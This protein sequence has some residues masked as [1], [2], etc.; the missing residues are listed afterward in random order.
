MVRDDPIPPSGW[1]LWLAFALPMALGLALR[2]AAAQGDYW[3]DEA[4]SALFARDAPTP[5]DLLFASGPG[6]GH[7]LNGLWLR[8]VGWGGPPLLGRALSIACGTAAIGVA[9]LIGLRRGL[10]TT[11]LTATMFAVSPILLTY[12]SEARGDAPMLLAL[13]VSIWIVDREL[14]GR[15]PRRAGPWLGLAALLG[16]FADMSMLFGIAAL[17]GWVLIEYGRRMPARRA[18]AAT[19]RLMGRPIGAVVAV[20]LLVLAAT[21]AGPEGAGVDGMAAFS[22]PAFVGALVDMLAF[23]IGWSPMIGLPMLA[24][25]LLP[26]AVRRTGAL[27]D[28]SPFFLI[29]I[30]GFPLLVALAEPDDGV[31]PRYYLLVSVALLLLIADLL[32]ALVARG[33]QA[34]AVATG[35]ILIAS[36]ATDTSIVQSRRGDP[37]R[38]VDAMMRRAPG[39][40]TVLLDHGGD[41]AV[42]ESA[43]ASRVYRLLTI[44][45]CV[46]ARFVYLSGNRTEP[47]PLAALRCGAAFRPIASGRAYGLSGMDWQL[48]ERVP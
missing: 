34:A 13:L 37:G 28:R 40:A 19:A 11:L 7:V 2:I 16:M 31:W 29:A 22:W 15:P 44:D 23:T 32:A 35:M 42:L 14:F 33:K 39:G 12:G 24:L 43:A 1:K 9:G 45:S 26:V 4:W 18:V 30:L 48:Y 8:F 46:P 6:D 21:L 17:S 27:A 36:L 41:G 5:G 10:G 20:L 38:A 25:L 3:L 47:F